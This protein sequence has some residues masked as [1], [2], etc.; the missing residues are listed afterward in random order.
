MI[1]DV[2]SCAAPVSCDPLMPRCASFGTSSPSYHLSRPHILDSRTGTVAIVRSLLGR[3]SVA[4]QK[5][6]KGCTALS[7]AAEAGLTEVAQVA[8]AALVACTPALVWRCS[9]WALLTGV[10][11]P[12]PWVALHNCRC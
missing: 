5:S 1:F 4:K 2:R 8:F 7:M 11:D 6:R 12:P 10:G 9:C 3:G